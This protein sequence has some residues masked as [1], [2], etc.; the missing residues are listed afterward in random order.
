MKFRI[1]YRTIKTAVGAA[2][3]SLIATK[4]RLGK[5]CFSWNLNHFMY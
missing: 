1:G 4:F 5:L 2:L 3:L